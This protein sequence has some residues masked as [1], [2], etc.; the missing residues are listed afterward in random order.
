MPAFK[1]RNCQAWLN[2]LTAE[3]IRDFSIF[4]PNS[5]RTNSEACLERKREQTFRH[6]RKKILSLSK[7]L[8]FQKPWNLLNRWRKAYNMI[9]VHKIL[10]HCTRAWN[11]MKEVTTKKLQ[12]IN[13]KLMSKK[14]RYQKFLTLNL[15]KKLV[16]KLGQNLKTRRK[17]QINWNNKWTN[18]LG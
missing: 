2:T 14:K 10:N 1:H 12:K 3:T 6:V 11:V 17:E 15:K 8:T 16:K 13:C 5:M 4:N 7:S 18:N 9:H